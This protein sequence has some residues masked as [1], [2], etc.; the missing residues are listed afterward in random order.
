M[1]IEI[2]DF[3]IKN[4]GSFHSYVKLPEGNSA[5]LKKK[6]RSLSTAGPVVPVVLFLTK[7][8]HP[9]QRILAPTRPLGSTEDFSLFS[10]GDLLPF[11]IEHGHLPS[12]KH[13]NNQTTMENHHFQWV[14]PLFLW[15]CSIAMLVYQRVLR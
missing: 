5:H 1:A 12:G 10:A 9:L 14:N 4:G 8:I 13:T 3:P 7:G 2:V 6:Q 11:A 15:P